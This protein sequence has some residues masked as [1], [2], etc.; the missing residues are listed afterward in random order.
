MFSK[1]QFVEFFNL[2]NKS[3]SANQIDRIHARLEM[4]QFIEA[5]GREK[6]DEMWELIKRGATPST[7][8][9]EEK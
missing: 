7:Q 1:D 6:C 8:Y 4:P 2:V 9:P 3:G 5:V